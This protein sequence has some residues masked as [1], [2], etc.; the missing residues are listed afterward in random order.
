[1][2]HRQAFQTD[3]FCKFNL[4]N[5]LLTMTL[6]YNHF[7]NKFNQFRHRENP[8]I[9]TKIVKIGPWTPEMPLSLYGWRPSWIWPK[10]MVKRVE[11][12]EP[13]DFLVI[14]SLMMQYPPLTQFGQTNLANSFFVTSPTI[15]KILYWRIKMHSALGE[16]TKWGLSWIST[17][18]ISK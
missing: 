16:S 11:K 2:R 15:N 1:M 5:N 6:T 18:T 3:I 7:E 17:S 13:Y 10:R 8:T 12:F 9:D 4:E 14:W